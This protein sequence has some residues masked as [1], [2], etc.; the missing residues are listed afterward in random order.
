MKTFRRAI[1]IQT[2]GP[3]AV[4]P[5]NMEARQI[6]AE[7]LLARAQWEHMKSLQTL[8]Y[9]IDADTLDHGVR[10]DPDRLV[11]WYVFKARQTRGLL[12]RI[13]WAISL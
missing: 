6:D 1:A 8:G 4:E 13:R 3:D 5:E 12:E 2:A 7:R 9:E 10:V 11:Y